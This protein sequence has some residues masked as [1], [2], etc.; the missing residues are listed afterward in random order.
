MVGSVV[1]EVG[2]SHGGVPA[3]GL[4]TALELRS[5]PELLQA[6][7]F[8]PL[9]R[10]ELTLRVERALAE[11]P[12]LTRRAGAPCPGCGRHLTSPGCPRCRGPGVASRA[13]VDAVTRPFDTTE[14]AAGWEIR[15]D[16]RHALPVVVAHLTDRGLLD[17][18]PEDIADLHGVAVAAVEEA[19]RA[20]KVAGPPGVAERT[21]GDLL[22]AQARALVDTGEAPPLL[23]EVVREHL[24][25]VAA[26]DRDAVAEALGVSPGQVADLFDLVRT[27]LRPAA[28]P[29][30]AEPEVRAAPDVLVH[31]RPGGGFDVEVADSGWYG[32]AVARESAAVR[33]DREAAAWLKPHEQ[34]ARKL[35]RGLDLR[36][37]V[38]H[39]VATAAVGHQGAFLDHGPPGHR[40]LTR[41][42]V[43]DDLGLHPSTV[44]RAVAGKALRHPDGRVVPLATLFGTA[45]PVKARVAELAARGG[46]SDEGIRAALAGEGVRVARR[47]VAKYRAGLGLPASR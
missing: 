36:A 30:D 2:V 27:R 18:D 31:R 8:L 6:L 46:L 41:A 43:A 12:A 40:D 35:I 3:L 7:E 10:D 5:L 25:A 21:V 39:R 38:L 24:P 44:S 26:D 29:E 11:N 17:A 32:L 20:L 33:A 22:A 37:D 15:S 1:G 19:V 13:A 23:V 28:T 42:R 16:C 45:V 9:A 14:T 4:G 34:A 47:T